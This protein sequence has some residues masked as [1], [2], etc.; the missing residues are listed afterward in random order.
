[1][2]RLFVVVVSMVYMMAGCADLGLALGTSVAAAGS[3]AA[4]HSITGEPGPTPPAI[5][6][7]TPD[8]ITVWYDKKILSDQQHEEAE[9]LV[10]EHCGKDYDVLL[11]E[12]DGSFV[13]KATCD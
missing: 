11:T 12:L 9:Q 4:T 10:I 3:E 6:H 13:I 2:T 1:M 7:S 5:V 8:S